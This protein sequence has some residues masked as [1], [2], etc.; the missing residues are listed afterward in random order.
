MSRTRSLPQKPEIGIIDRAG[1]FRALLA[2]QLSD[3]AS[4]VHEAAS[5]TEGLA[6]VEKNPAITIVIIEA[7]LPDGCGFEL[8]LRLKRRRQDHLRLVL[9]GDPVSPEDRWRA[10]Q[11]GADACL[12]KPVSGIEILAALLR[13]ASSSFVERA[14][15]AP[16]R[17]LVRVCHA[18]D[19]E[20]NP[21]A[22]LQWWLRDLSMAGAFLETH[23]P[24]RCGTPLRLELE[25]AGGARWLDATVV[26]EQAP[27]WSGPGGVGVLFHELAPDTR[28]A[29]AEAV[30]E[31]PDLRWH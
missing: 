31:S 18:A 13:T 15:R 22:Q 19:P 2:S 12:E 27:S 11:I 23:G 25:L 6:L 16:I 7:T 1:G 5:V 8:G 28:R 20:G 24:V 30:G 26:R 4:A 3:G 21:G 14:H 29:L 17:E 9:L 10:A